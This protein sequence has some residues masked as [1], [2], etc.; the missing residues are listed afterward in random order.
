MLTGFNTA[1]P[2]KFQRTL[3]GRGSRNPCQ[4]YA[5]A[6]VKV[7]APAAPPHPCGR[8]S[9]QLLLDRAAAI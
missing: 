7:N 2:V 5:S 1:G 6:A 4:L 3:S 8:R 9:F